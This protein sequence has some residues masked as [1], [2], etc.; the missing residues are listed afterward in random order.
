MIVCFS[1]ASARPNLLDFMFQHTCRERHGDIYSVIRVSAAGSFRA[2][3]TFVRPVPDNNIPEWS[4]NRL[5]SFTGD[6]E[7]RETNPLSCK[8]RP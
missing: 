1:G 4:A 2:R 6:K 3:D 5:L 7:R 8:A